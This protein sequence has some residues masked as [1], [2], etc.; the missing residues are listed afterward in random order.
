MAEWLIIHLSGAYL[1][2]ILGHAHSIVHENL[3]HAHSLMH[4]HPDQQ[5]WL[6]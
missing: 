3:G 5:C 1:Q 6:P 2:F 4:G